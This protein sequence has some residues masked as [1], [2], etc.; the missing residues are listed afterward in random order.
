MGHRQEP[1]Y[2]WFFHGWSYKEDPCMTRGRDTSV[3]EL[4]KADQS[5]EDEK[6]E[7]WTLSHTDLFQVHILLNMGQLIWALIFQREL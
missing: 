6:V 7:S 5:A 2:L 1:N 3:L 4:N